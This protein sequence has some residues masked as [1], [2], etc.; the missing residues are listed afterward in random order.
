M[1]GF[2]EDTRESIEKTIDFAIEANPT[3]AN[4][5]LLL[6]FPG[7]EMYREL[8]ASGNLKDPDKLFYDTGFLSGKIHFASSN[9]TEQELLQYESL[10]YRRFNFRFRKMVEVLFSIRSFGELVWTFEAAFPLIKQMFH[11][12]GVLLSRR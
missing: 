5:A 6:P 1:I 2:P 7:T 12:T 10:A 9:L 11:R 4:F 3:V 8:K